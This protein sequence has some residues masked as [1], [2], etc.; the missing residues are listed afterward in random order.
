MKAFVDKGFSESRGSVSC[1]CSTCG[2]VYF[3]T[4]KELAYRIDGLRNRLTDDSIE[5]HML[6][7]TLGDFK[8]ENYAEVGAILSHF[9]D[10]CIYR[11]DFF[12]ERKEAGLDNQ[13]DEC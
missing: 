11:W 2:A 4:A 1:C 13:D 5:K 9:C 3:R 6:K 7:E 12:D 10:F 8:P